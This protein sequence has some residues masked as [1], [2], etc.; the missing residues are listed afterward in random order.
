MLLRHE[1][2]NKKYCKRMLDVIFTLGVIQRDD[3]IMGMI[4]EYSN[5]NTIK[6]PENCL[7]MMNIIKKVSLLL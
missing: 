4:I 5:V 3:A 1:R 6:I 7:Y 2:S